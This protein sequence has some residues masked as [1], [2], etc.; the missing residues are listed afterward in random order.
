MLFKIRLAT[1]A[2]QEGTEYTDFI[3]FFIGRLLQLEE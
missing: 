3:A 1:R 2:Y